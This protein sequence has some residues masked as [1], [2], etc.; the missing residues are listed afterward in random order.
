MST[1]D[2]WSPFKFLRRDNRDGAPAPSA[3]SNSPVRAEPAPVA[4]IDPR[5]PFASMVRMMDAMWRDPFFSL[6]P[7]AELDRWF[8][9]FSPSRFTVSS[10]V[11]DEGKAVRV[12]FEVP[13]M[14]R[15]DITLSVDNGVLVLRGQKRHDTESSE[16]GVFRTERFF[17]SIQR[18]IPL[19]RDLDFEAAEA[20]LK[21]GV[22]SVRLPKKPEAGPEAR[23]IPVR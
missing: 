4:P 13:G 8:G 7:S 1:L 23:T 11:V 14:A 10:D 21:D 18:A 3:S 5:D 16:D 12:D 6:R 17:G 15:E 22:L 19:P 20:S 2:K 9:D